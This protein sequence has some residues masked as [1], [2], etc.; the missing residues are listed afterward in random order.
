M[1]KT[2]VTY[3]DDITKKEASGVETVTFA[4][5]GEQFEIDLN[6]L[7]KANFLR[8]VRKYMENG[9]KVRTTGRT[10]RATRDV[11]HDR[12]Y[13]HKVRKWAQEQGIEVSN[14]GRVP[15]KVYDQFEAAHAALLKG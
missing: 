1:Q 12:E 8:S 9:R 10:H 7:N 15:L 13:V 4:V 5:E 14:R 11:R 2:V 3:T 6:P